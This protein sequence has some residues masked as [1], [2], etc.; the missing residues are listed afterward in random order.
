LPFMTAH[1]SHRGLRRGGHGPRRR[2][3]GDR[4]WDRPARAQTN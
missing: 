3:S 4:A 2:R 1:P